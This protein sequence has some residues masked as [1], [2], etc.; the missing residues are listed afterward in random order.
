MR[1]ARGKAAAK[2]AR[3][4]DRSRRWQIA[5]PTIAPSSMWPDVLIY[6]DDMPEPEGSAA[7]CARL[8]RQRCLRSHHVM[9]ISQQLRRPFRVSSAVLTAK[10]IPGQERLQSGGRWRS[11]FRRE[12]N[13]LLRTG[14]LCGCCGRHAMPRAAPPA[15]PALRLRASKP[16]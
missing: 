14:D 7:R 5:S 11:G 10:D 9:L 15:W 2:K 12:R 6:I 3:M 1:A 13:R 16:S 8:C 4:Q